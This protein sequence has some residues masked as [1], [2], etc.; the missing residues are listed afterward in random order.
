[1]K[2][3][4]GVGR[5]SGRGKNDVLK[6]SMSGDFLKVLIMNY[7]VGIEVRKVRIIL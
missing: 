3:G 6:L 1:M 4:G 5:L 7:C 2:P